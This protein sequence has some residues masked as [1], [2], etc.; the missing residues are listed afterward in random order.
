[1]GG[2]HPTRKHRAELIADTVCLIPHA[3]Q[4]AVNPPGDE[5]LVK[6]TRTANAKNPGQRARGSK[7][8]TNDATSYEPCGLGP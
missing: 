1:M 7:L 2:A 3:T 5:C 4:C 6:R 8:S